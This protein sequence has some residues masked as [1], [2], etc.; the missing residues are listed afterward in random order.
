[1]YFKSSRWYIISEKNIINNIASK[2][3]YAIV[4]SSRQ[5]PSE[6]WST[7]HDFIH[8]CFVKECTHISMTLEKL[9]DRTSKYIFKP[10]STNW[11]IVF[12]SSNT[13]FVCCDGEIKKPTPLRFVMQN[14]NFKII[15]IFDLHLFSKKLIN[16]QFLLHMEKKNFKTNLS[17]KIQQSTITERTNS[18]WLCDVLRS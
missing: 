4:R 7:E 1:M 9:F 12:Y 11:G 14:R 10:F 13:H 18:K 2:N 17:N 3:E 8:R 16:K 5:M 6:V 15:I